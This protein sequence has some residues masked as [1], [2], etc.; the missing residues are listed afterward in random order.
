MAQVAEQL[1]LSTGRV[2]AALK[3][4]G[5]PPRRPGW[6]DGRPPAPITL[7]QLTTLY[8][9]QGKSVDDVADELAT[10]STRVT[11]ALRR[12]GIPRRPE[13]RATPPPLEL[14]RTTLTELYVNR[15]LDDPASCTGCRRT[16]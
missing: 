7:E 1:N 6:A 4:A 13:P 15:R 16:G 8:V 5:I 12:H 2:P 11:A 9:D 14:D 3:D 10:T